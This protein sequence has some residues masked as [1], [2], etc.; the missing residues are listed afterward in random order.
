[1]RIFLWAVV[2]L[3]ALV[4][5]IVVALAIGVP[6]S[7]EPFREPVAAAASQ[8]LGRRVSIAGPFK[9]V[10]AFYPT[11]EIRGVSI[12]NPPEWPEGEFAHLD[13][14]RLQLGVLPLLW[15]RATVNEVRVEGVALRL[16]TNAD[17]AGNWLFER[18]TAA[19]NETEGKKPESVDEAAGAALGEIFA[20]WIR[21]VEL[22]ELALRNIRAE[23]R[24]AR[25]GSETSFV[26]EEVT[27]SAATDA[28][29]A[30]D[31]RGSLLDHPYTVGMHGGSLRGLFVA[32]DEPWPLELS[33]EIAETRLRVRALL[34]EPLL[35]PEPLEELTR[36]EGRIGAL[37]IEIAG[38]RLSTLDSLAQVNLPDWGPWA[39]SGGFAAHKG[40]RHGANVELTVGSSD[41]TGTME[42]ELRRD[43]PRFGVALIAETVQLDDFPLGGWSPTADE[44][45][46]ADVEANPEAEE[47]DP[48]AQPRA[49][50]SAETLARLDATL[51]VEIGRVLSGSD[52]LGASV[53]EAKLKQGQLSV[54][55][56]RVE[57]P[58][59]ALEV[60]GNLHPTRDEVR[61]ELGARIEQF[62]YGILA[63]RIDP[64]TDMSGLVTLDFALSSRAPTGEQIM[65]YANG[66]LDLGVF[67]KAF[68][69]GIIDLWAVNLVMAVIPVVDS[70]KDSVLNCVVASLDVKDG[71]MTQRSILMDTS[72]MRVSGEATA[73]FREQRVHARLKPKA[74]RP[75]FFSLAT[76]ITVDGTFK[77]FGVGVK[78]RSLLG[79]VVRLAASPIEVPIRYI[80]GDVLPADGT[81]DCSAALERVGQRPPAP[82]TNAP[83]NT[84]P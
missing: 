45:T 80:A 10:P 8:N 39:F 17:G 25:T 51:S 68:E 81:A 31:A 6:V 2:A 19:A 76:P 71:V 73:D 36:G 4:L 5:V 84:H 40:G 11:V 44:E 38:E 16:E 65:P 74:K 29:I 21:N 58:G 49:L 83:V 52:R 24:D 37:E 15:R 23:R 22:S 35:G 54:Q 78:P 70:G 63:R 27:G 12:A 66:H 1:V 55:P 59:G 42:V 18:A 62:D 47:A 57:V 14:A 41:L 53:L 64:E 33:L 28:P 13:L 20:R 75:Q 72:R 48:S 30:F 82:T 43:P 26:I 77:D 60:T 9:L 34:D 7:L 56:W 61:A 3:A 79:T 67:P 69:A 46:P 32:Q 50:F